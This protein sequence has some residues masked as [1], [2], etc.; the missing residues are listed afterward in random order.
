MRTLVWRY[1]PSLTSQIHRPPHENDQG[2][3]ISDSFEPDPT[4]KWEEAEKRLQ[5]SYQEGGFPAWTE[6]AIKELENEVKI[7][8]ARRQKEYESSETNR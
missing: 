8:R 2:V 1:L 7:E 3:P 6:T 5:A 4:W